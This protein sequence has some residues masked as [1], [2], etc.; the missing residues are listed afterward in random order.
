MRLYWNRPP[1]A[2]SDGSTPPP[3]LRIAQPQACL[4]PLACES[5]RGLGKA[6]ATC[7]CVLSCFGHVAHPPAPLSMGFSRQEYWS[8]LPHPSP[9]DLPDP[10]IKPK[11]LISPAS[12]GGI[13]T[14]SVTWESHKA[15]FTILENWKPSKCLTKG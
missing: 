1:G 15:L 7:V 10:G 8:G 5:L 9:G 13:F 4:K 6:E 2:Y 14:A 11:S 12:G 3:P